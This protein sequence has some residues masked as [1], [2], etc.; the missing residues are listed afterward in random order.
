V[1]R[2]VLVVEKDRLLRQSIQH[3]LKDSYS[4]RGVASVAA[5]RSSLQTSE[6]DAIVIGCSL[7]ATPCAELANMARKLSPHIR[8]IISPLY[9]DDLSDCECCSAPCD[10]LLVKPFDLST[11]KES[12]DALLAPP[13]PGS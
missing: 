12:L 4:I 1:T 5:A 7:Q 6:F 8:V 11:L 13:S 2:Q 10:A 9:P 3:S